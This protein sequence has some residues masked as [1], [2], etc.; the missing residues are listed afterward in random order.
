M[1]VSAKF[2]KFPFPVIALH[3]KILSNEC[4]SK[5]FVIFTNFW[6]PIIGGIL[7][8]GP[9]VCLE[10]QVSTQIW[11]ERKDEVA[12]LICQIV[13][14]RRTQIRKCWWWKEEGIGREVFSSGFAVAAQPS[15]RLFSPSDICKKLSLTFYVSYDTTQN[16]RV[17]YLAP[18]DLQT[19]YGNGFFGLGWYW[20]VVD[21]LG[22]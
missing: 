3:F 9:T 15:G 10:G 13:P 5:G 21:H 22:P 16:I 11:E 19:H 14:L 18:S 2:T 4:R 6:N 1:R 17:C 20:E 7:K 8:L 12:W